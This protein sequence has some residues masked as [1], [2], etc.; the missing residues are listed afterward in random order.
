MTRNT[1]ISNKFSTPAEP[2]PGRG[3]LELVSQVAGYRTMPGSMSA[4]PKTGG[5]AARIGYA[6]TRPVRRLTIE[7]NLHL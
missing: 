4:G 6:N 3:I 5:I 1:K 2:G 7:V